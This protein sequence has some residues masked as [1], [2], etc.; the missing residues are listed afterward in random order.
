MQK[1]TSVWKFILS[2]LFLSAFF[3][4]RIIIFSRFLYLIRDRMN[5]IIHRYVLTFAS[6][7]PSAAPASDSGFMI[8]LF[9]SLRKARH[10]TFRCRLIEKCLTRQEENDEKKF[11]NFYLCCHRNVRNR[12]NEM[13]IAFLSFLSGILSALLLSKRRKCLCISQVCM[14]IC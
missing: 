6:L 13:W 1:E 8:N 10:E 4:F 9:V 5:R 7:S 2:S 12:W 11:N 3:L 14:F